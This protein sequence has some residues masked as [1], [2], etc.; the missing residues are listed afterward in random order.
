MRGYYAELGL[1]QHRAADMFVA[2][3]AAVRTRNGE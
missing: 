1:L 2:L 3:D